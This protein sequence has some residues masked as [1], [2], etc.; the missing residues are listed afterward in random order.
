MTV[1]M[2]SFCLAYI[3][4]SITALVSMAFSLWQWICS[5]KATGS[6]PVFIMFVYFLL[7]LHYFIIIIILLPIGHFVR[8]S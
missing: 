6:H 5:Q 3:D 1:M 2:I 7:Y 8:N 4:S